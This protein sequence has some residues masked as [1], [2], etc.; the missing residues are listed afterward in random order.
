MPLTL[1]HCDK[2]EGSGILQDLSDGLHITLA[3]AVMLMIV[4]SDNTATNL[5]LGQ[6]GIAPVNDTMER[7]GLP[8][9]RLYKKVF[10]PAPEPE[11][12]DAKRFGL[13]KTTVNDM[14]RLLRLINA[15]QVVDA[16]ASDRMIEIL[17]KQRDNDAF[18]RYLDRFGTR[19][20]PITVAHKTGALD[21]LRNDVGIVDTPRGKLAMA[22]FAYDS[23]D[24][25]WTADNAATLV[26]A[27]L[28]EAVV[29]DTMRTAPLI[30]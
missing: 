7:L 12:E 26:L 11:S 4:E 21:E 25:S 15:R 18:P 27:K 17:K 1:H 28:A 20:H 13:G 24:K 8:D 10:L 23:P 14:L 2:V 3:D 22:G 16:S 9:T 6:V 5:V 30:P 19:D 29:A